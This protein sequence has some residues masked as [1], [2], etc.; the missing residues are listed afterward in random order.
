[1]AIKRLK[2]MTRGKIVGNFNKGGGY[3]I[4]KA[5]AIYDF[6]SIVALTLKR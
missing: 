2:P 5:H 6:N 3:G 4:M 1:M